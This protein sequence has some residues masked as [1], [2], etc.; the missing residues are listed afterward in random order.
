MLTSPDAMP[1]RSRAN[2][3]TAS[4]ITGPDAIPMPMP[5]RPP[6]A[7]KRTRLLISR[8]PRTPNSAIAMQPMPSATASREPIVSASFV[9]KGELAMKRMPH[10]SNVRPVVNAEAYISVWTNLG[11]AKKNAYI[12]K[13]I[14]AIA[15]SAASKRTTRKASSGTSGYAAAR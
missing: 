2:V 13:V 11:N 6:I 12:P 5:V 8:R 15:A 9:A 3:S 7:A 1:A 14:H 10:G 4:D